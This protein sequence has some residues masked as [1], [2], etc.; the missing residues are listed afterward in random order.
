MSPEQTQLLWKRSVAEGD[1]ARLK[2]KSEDKAHL[3]REAVWSEWASKMFHKKEALVDDGRWN[4][5]KDRDGRLVGANEPTNEWLDEATVDFSN[6][7]FPNNFYSRRWHFPGPARFNNTKFLANADFQGAHFHLDADFELAHFNK[8]ATFWKAKFKKIAFFEGTTFASYARFR[9]AIF[10]DDAWFDN[11]SFGSYVTFREAEIF[12]RAKFHGAQFARSMSIHDTHFKQVPDFRQA[13]FTEAP[14][15]QPRPLLP[16]APSTEVPHIQH[17][18]IPSYERVSTGKERH[19]L[20]AR[21]RALKR[22]AIQGHDYEFE[23]SFF[24]DEL[25]ARRGVQ[26]FM[27]PKFDKSGHLSWTVAVRFWFGQAY[28]LLS[29]FGRSL[30]R[31]LLAWLVVTV[32]FAGYYFIQRSTPS[33]SKVSAAGGT[34][35]VHR[36]PQCRDDNYDAV[37]AALQY[38]FNRGFIV[39]WD[40]PETDKPA[41]KCLYGSDADGSVIPGGVVF[42]GKAQTLTSAVLVFLFLL[43]LRN[44]FRIK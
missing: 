27:L 6:F 8:V 12:G 23:V 44:Q 4:L 18:G 36:G 19:N 21:Y 15:F 3:A 17:A 39:G 20:S 40:S 38:A 2:W 24:A 22:L 43:A 11:A 35:T 7:E 42:A 34:T 29:D 10:D 32:L 1:A 41:L 13:H 9:E 33:L 16:E 14:I 30:T 26:D 37:Y 31:P 28:E 25:K 5:R